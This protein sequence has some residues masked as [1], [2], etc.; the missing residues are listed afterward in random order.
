[1]ERGLLVLRFDKMAGMTTLARV[2][3]LPAAAVLVLG[4]S[5]AAFSAS[6]TPVASPAGAGIDL[7]GLD[8]SVAPG[9]DFFR[10]A[11]GTWM[12]TTEIPPDRAAYGADAILADLTNQRTADLIKEASGARSEERRVGKECRA[13]G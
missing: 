9:D 1:M 12:K 11:N 4:L 6:P 7:A 10:Y 3:S 2:A 8:R 13:R 5:P